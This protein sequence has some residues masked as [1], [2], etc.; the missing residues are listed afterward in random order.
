[1]KYVD[2]YLQLKKLPPFEQLTDTHVEGDH[3]SNY[4]ENIYYWLATTNFKTNEGFMMQSGKETKFDQIK[5]IFSLRRI[6]CGMT[7]NIL[8]L[9]RN[10]SGRNVSVNK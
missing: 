1:M 3:L 8:K 6:H 10:G 7:L 9:Q 5:V 2:D 4:L